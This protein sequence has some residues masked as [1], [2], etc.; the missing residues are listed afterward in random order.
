MR[1]TIAILLAMTGAGSA[2]E[3]LP[4]QDTSARAAALATITAD[5][6]MRDVGVLA[7]DSLRGRPTPSRELD[8]AAAY[9]AEELRRGGVRPLA[10]HDMVIRWPLINTTPLLDRIKLVV[11]S[12]GRTASLAYGTEFALMPGGPTPVSGRLVAVPDLSDTARIRGRIPVLQLPPGGWS[13]PAHVAMNRARQARARALVLIL[14]PAQPVGPVAAAGAKMDHASTGVPTVLVT[15]A[16]ADRLTG[17]LTL[18]VPERADTLSAPYVLGVV[19]GSDRRL[20]DEYVILTAHL[21]H[22]G[23]GAPDERGDSIYNGADDNASGVAA[24]LAAARAIAR[25][26]PAPR[27]SLLFLVVSGEEIGIRGSDYFTRQPPVPLAHI[28]ADVNLDGIGRSWQA[29]TV[30]AEGGPFSSLGATV[31]AAAREHADLGLTVVDDQWPDRT[32]FQTSDQI[33]FARRGV[34]SVFF[35]SSGPD[36]HYHRPSDEPAT[37][38]PD[39]TARIAR[40]AAW[41]AL[42]IADDPARPTWV[43]SARR[44]LELQ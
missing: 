25:A 28:V 20:R 29:D 2:A 41:T 27:R 5:G 44:S 23:V 11:G 37:I 15:P 26:R 7:D 38:E 24:V 22:L 31:R 12:P 8:A 6:I 32:Y 30:S 33:W 4:A 34:P 13:G 36:A 19:P 35:S 1:L 16:T 40:L 9:V 10:G 14:D 21:D 3:A 18:T 43:E 17:T 42:R 39:F